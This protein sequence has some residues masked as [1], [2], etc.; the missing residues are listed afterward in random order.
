VR[1]QNVPWDQVLHDI[2][3]QTGVAVQVK[4]EL[5]GTVT[6]AFDALPLEEGLRHLFHGVNIVLFY[7]REGRLERRV[8]HVWIFPRPGNTAPTDAAE[9][10]HA[11][12][13]GLTALQ[14]FAPQGDL[15]ALQQAL[16][17]P[18]PRIRTTALDLL[19]AWDS[20]DGRE[21][22][23][24]A[25]TSDQP[26]T[27]VRALTLLH[28]TDLG[29]EGVVLSALAQ[30][31]TDPDVTVKAYALH[32]LTQR[33]SPEAVGVMGQA[34]HDSEASIRQMAIEHIASKEEGRALLREALSHNDDTIRA[35][36]AFW[37]EQ[38][39]AKEP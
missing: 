6:Q 16:A 39:A 15:E 2:E 24:R 23:L 28:E 12:D 27:R 33:G 4:G 25:I 37:L 18:D 17:D 21:L 5:A 32:A 29:Q 14:K 34:L 26:A 38:A 7:A 10:A 9:P 35:L 20:Q 13:E 8:S 30:A 11:P 19:P 31:L 22:L 36:A 1:L 3:R